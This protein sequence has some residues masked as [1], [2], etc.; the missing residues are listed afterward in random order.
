MLLSACQVLIKF[1]VFQ[2]PQ[3]WAY[4]AYT[5]TS[6]GVREEMN[7][8]GVC[9]TQP[10]EHPPALKMMAIV[11]LS[12]GWIVELYGPPSAI[13]WLPQGRE[14]PIARG[15]EELTEILGLTERVGDAINVIMCEI[16]FICVLL[17]IPFER[18]KTN[19]K[20]SNNLSVC[21]A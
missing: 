9:L 10:G 19:K 6:D 20:E 17:E 14:L 2:D 8:T 4:T 5:P 15:D 1:C 16:W 18:G 7:T 13:V 12:A 21:F 3:T 11:T